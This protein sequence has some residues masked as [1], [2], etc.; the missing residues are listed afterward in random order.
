MKVT[1][2]D[3]VS[4][5]AHFPPILSDSIRKNTVAA[6]S[7]IEINQNEYPTK[8]PDCSIDPPYA[9]SAVPLVARRHIGKA[10]YFMNLNASIRIIISEYV[11]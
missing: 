9:A 10:M 8:S 2:A 3:T 7:A 6:A 4:D 11:I 5:V 1:S